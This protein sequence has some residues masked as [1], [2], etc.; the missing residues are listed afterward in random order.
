[1]EKKKIF[2]NF[3]DKI[4]HKLFSYLNIK[5][6]TVL[7]LL[8]KKTSK[9]VLKN[10]IFIKFLKIKKEFSN[11]K[12]DQAN[13]KEKKIK[14]LGIRLQQAKTSMNNK[15]NITQ[16]KQNNISNSR[17]A[18]IETT[19]NEKINFDLVNIELLVKN[20]A[21]KIKKLANKYSLSKEEALS[22][23]SGLIEAKMIKQ[24]SQKSKKECQIKALPLGIGITYLQ[25]ALSSFSDIVKLDFSGNQISNKNF[26]PLSNLISNL[27]FL[28][29]LN[30][31]DNKINDSCC[32]QLFQ[33][34]EHNKVINHLNLSKNEISSE[35]IIF[36]NRFLSS[37]TSLQTL[38]FEQNILG[39]NGIG[40]LSEFLENNTSI[41]S[42][43]I[44]YNGIQEEG[45]KKIKG[46]LQ[47]NTKIISL[48]IGG[49][50]ICDNGIKELIDILK[51]GSKISYLFLETNNISSKGA[52]YITKIAMF[53]PF[54]M[55]LNLKNNNL[56]DEGVIQIFKS[57]QHESKLVSLDLTNNN[58]TYKSIQVIASSLE[59]N[60]TLGSLILNKNKIG[61][62]GCKYI[63]QLIEKNNSLINLS[64]VKC[65]IEKGIDIILE[66]LGHNKKISVIDF[67][68]NSLGNNSQLFLS[69][70]A[71]LKENKTLNEIIIDDAELN[72]IDVKV[73]CAGLCDNHTIKKV[74]LNKNQFTN[75]ILFDILNSITKSKSIKY[76][77]IDKSDFSLIDKKEIE[78][79]LKKNFQL[80]K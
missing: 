77:D 23:F 15:Q 74:S 10:E 53:H 8:N 76:F 67:S 26:T 12:D 13:K 80:R 55:S 25:H 35:G 60:K 58:L 44:G 29:V 22:I 70:V 3:D 14:T 46:T 73:L 61:K 43:N 65:E 48:F 49:N 34:L 64:L 37:T 50:Y 75:K 28:L 33:G 17:S 68:R 57:L 45:V 42:L 41:R 16:G 69:F 78:L 62:E 5:T 24:F 6:I 2:Q 56:N 1:M 72:D 38:N 4:L 47:K 54:I 19:K 7:L 39:A 36:A 20:D 59:K 27:N 30:L 40:F 9:F 52:E 63:A 79:A 11:N 21:E 51:E 71:C 32:K 31:S 18:D 66:K